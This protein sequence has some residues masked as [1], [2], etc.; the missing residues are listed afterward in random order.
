M[1]SCTETGPDTMTSNF[2]LQHTNPVNDDV[3]FI[4]VYSTRENAELAIT[5]LSQ[6]P[7]FVQ[8][9]DGFS[10]DEYDLDVDHWTEGFCTMTSIEVAVIGIDNEWRSVL[11][12]QIADDRFIIMHDDH[13]PHTEQWEFTKGDVVTCRETEFPDGSIRLVA[14]KLDDRT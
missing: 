7:G 13:R 10:I 11:A 6:L 1:L 12:E 8:S 2:V 5:R 4:G 14:S 3:K 9:Q